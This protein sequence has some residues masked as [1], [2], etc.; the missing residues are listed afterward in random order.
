MLCSR[1]RLEIFPVNS[2]T[3]QLVDDCKNQLDLN[4]SNGVSHW[5]FFKMFY[6]LYSNTMNSYS[7]YGSGYSGVLGR[8][9]EDID[10]NEL[11]KSLYNLVNEPVLSVVVPPPERLPD[12]SDYVYV[13]TWKTD[14]RIFSTD[15]RD[16]IERSSY[17]RLLPEILKNLEINNKMRQDNPLKVDPVATLVPKLEQAYTLSPIT[18]PE[19]KIPPVQGEIV[20]RKPGRPKKPKVAVANIIETPRR[21]SRKRKSVF[22][23]NM[24]IDETNDFLDNL[25]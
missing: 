20:K 10:E 18:S 5:K 11:R 4:G 22:D 8:T 17:D 16:L 23:D 1:A 19:K 24:N 7:G 15:P 14:P 21:S 13:A 9:T 3:I 25:Q 12:T 2:C 6:V